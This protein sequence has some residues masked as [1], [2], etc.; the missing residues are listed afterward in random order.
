MNILVTGRKGYIS[1]S[2]AESLRTKGHTVKQISIRSKINEAEL[3]NVEVI[4]HCAA[5]VHK[6]EKNY[7]LEEYERVNHKKTVELAS[8]AKE[9]GVRLFIFMST[10]SVYGASQGIITETTPL[11]PSTFYG[12][13]KLHAEESLLSMEDNNFGVA[14]IRPPMVYGHQAPG[15]YQS[16]S[17]LAKVTPIFPIVKNQRSMIYIENLIEFISQVVDF[18]DNGVFHPQNEEYVQTSEMVR[19]IANYHGKRIHFSSLLGYILMSLLGSRKIVNK[20]FGDLFYSKTLSDYRGNS[21]QTISFKESISQ[22]EKSIINKG[23]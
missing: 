5:M 21:Y 10:M 1:S 13:S 20:V 8:L 22:S 11:K 4:I 17:K 12:I 23:V 7:S 3:S 18:G 2:L 15:N 16:L 14:I 6:K 9:Q 19:Q